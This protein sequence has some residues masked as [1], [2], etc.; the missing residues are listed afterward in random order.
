MTTII[1]VELK[2]RVIF[3]SDSQATSGYSKIH[4]DGGKIETVGEYTFGV[5]GVAE[6]LLRLRR[7]EWPVVEG[8][9][10]EHV[11]E[12]LIPFLLEQQS[13]IFKDFGISEEDDNPFFSPPISSVI[14]SVRGRVY[15]L[16]L[17]KG[18]SPIRRAHGTYSIG[19]GADYALGALAGAQKLDEKAVLRALEAAARNDIGTSGPF[20]V[21]TIRTR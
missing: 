12:R 9:T 6:L 4:M 19:S 16:N 5:A 8:D 3:G 21:K 13:Q 15:D 2:N 20:T 7:I 17:V 18:L 10:D 11:H 1:A 14:V